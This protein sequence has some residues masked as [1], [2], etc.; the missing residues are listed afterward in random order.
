MEFAKTIELNAE[1]LYHFNLL[2]GKKVFIYTPIVVFLVTLG[3]CLNVVE[4][5]LLPVMI[6]VIISFAIV[7]LAMLLLKR[8]VNKR[9]ASDRITR[10]PQQIKLDNIGLH[11]SCEIDASN[12][13]WVDF[14]SAKESKHAF[15]FILSTRSGYIIPKRL[16]EPNEVAIIRSI[17]TKK[18]PDKDTSLGDEY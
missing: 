5:Y 16:L 3:I 9:Y 12:I 18:F 15:Y 2:I 10:L 1:D 17:I 6:S 14:D 11:S 7:F 13:P 8:K 4:N